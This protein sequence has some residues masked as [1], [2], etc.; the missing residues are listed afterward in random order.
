VRPVVAAFFCLATLSAAAQDFGAIAIQQ[1]QMANQQAQQ[2]MQQASDQALRD[3]QV[4]QSTPCCGFAARPSFSIKPGQYSGPVT[5]RLKSRS[6]GATIFYTT[7]G[8]TPT[9]LSARYTGPIH[10]AATTTLQAIAIAPQQG[11]SAIAVAVYTLPGQPP[12]VASLSTTLPALLP[13]TPLLLTFTTPV[14]SKGLQVGD[15]VPIALAQDLYLAGALA[16]PKSTPVLATVTQ[17][18]P[19]GRNG[20]PATLTFV[21][22]SITVQ[23]Q[24][25]PLFATET[26]EGLPRHRA[27]YIFG[28]VP[29]AGIITAQVRGGDAAIAQGTPLTAIVDRG[30]PTSPASK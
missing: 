28:A 25:V 29:I 6:R 11:R 15:T 30:S 13:G 21:V 18:D 9:P 22:H 8:W 7:D 20:L 1:T 12:P 3:A 23:G 17:V 27:D 10:L 4:A 16:A 24:S 14:T 2:S 19:P 5:V 26:K